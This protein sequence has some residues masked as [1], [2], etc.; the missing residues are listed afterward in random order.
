MIPFEQ[1]F[2]SVADVGVR[3]A[4]WRAFGLQTPALDAQSASRGYLERDCNRWIDSWQTLPESE[5]LGA[6]VTGMPRFGM[7]SIVEIN[8]AGEIEKFIAAYPRMTMGRQYTVEIVRVELAPDRLQMRIVG[9]VL[10]RAGTPGERRVRLAFYDAAG[11]VNRGFYRRGSRHDFILTGITMGVWSDQPVDGRDGELL[12]ES[13]QFDPDDKADEYHFRIKVTR[14]EPLHEPI[15]GNPAWSIRGVAAEDA[16]SPLEVEMLA[17]APAIVGGVPPEPGEIVRGKLWLQGQLWSL[18]REASPPLG[19][20]CVRFE[21][22]VRPAQ[23]AGAVRLWELFGGMSAARFNDE[24]MPILSSPSWPMILPDRRAILPFVEPLPLGEPELTTR[25]AVGLRWGLRSV[26]CKNFDGKTHF[27][28]V[29][30]VVMDETE[31]LIRINA[32]DVSEDRAEARV[33]GKLLAADDPE[34]DAC[35]IGFYDLNWNVSRQI[36]RKGDVH[37]FSLVLIAYDLTPVPDDSFSMPTPDWMK[38]LA[39]GGDPIFKTVALNETVR[40]DTS[41]LRSF[42]TLDDRGRRADEASFRGKVLNVQRLPELYLGV[43]AWEFDVEVL[44][45]GESPLVLKVFATESA[46]GPGTVPTRGSFV[47]GH[48][49]L[50]GRLMRPIRRKVVPA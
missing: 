3:D 25:I 43:S 35:A 4:H 1:T 30:P 2:V 45:W 36:L 42:R 23:D 8:K 47:H 15:F 28:A 27:V 6:T 33:V 50:L 5:P 17:A 19:D 38:E 22:T 41:Q 37:A 44:E 7:R 9:D 40:M 12:L 18:E 31:H 13:L 29:H 48:G 49:W 34:S 14:V 16:A 11:P 21:D 32:I 39:E 46:L 24:I 10:L 20:A 26:W